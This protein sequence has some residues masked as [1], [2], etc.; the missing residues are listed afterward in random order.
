MCVQVCLPDGEWLGCI[1]DLRDHGFTVPDDIIPN[2]VADCADDPT[3]LTA[4]EAEEACFCSIHKSELER[5][6][7]ANGCTWTDDLSGDY[8]ITSGPRP[9]E[10]EADSGGRQGDDRC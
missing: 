6:L 4:A 10:P 5:I 8:D 2:M 7:M 9:N 1:N 3:P